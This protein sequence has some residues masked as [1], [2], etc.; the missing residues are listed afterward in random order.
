VQYY[1]KYYGASMVCIMSYGISVTRSLT[2][3][4]RFCAGTVNSAGELRGLPGG[5][6]CAAGGS[7]GEGRRGGQGWGRGQHGHL[8]QVKLLSTD[9]HYNNYYLF[10]IFLSGSQGPI[11]V[12]TVV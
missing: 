9:C 1:H 12:F 7:Q 10:I 8:E 4:N 5:V 11:H 2:Q 3:Y 6:P